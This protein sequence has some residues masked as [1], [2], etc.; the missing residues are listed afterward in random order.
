MPRMLHSQHSCALLGQGQDTTCTVARIAPSHG[1]QCC[2]AYIAYT[3]C[4]VA[5]PAL[6]R[7][8]H[9]LDSLHCCTACVA[10][11]ACTVARPALLRSKH[12]CTACT[13]AQP[14]QP[15]IPRARTR[16]RHAHHREVVLLCAVCRYFFAEMLTKLAGLGPQLYAA[17]K[18]NWF[19]ALVT[20]VG[21][22][23]FIISVLPSANALG[24][25]MSVFRAFRL[26]RILRLARSW[27]SLLLN[28]GLHVLHCPQLQPSSHPQ[29]FA[30]FASKCFMVDPPAAALLVHCW[31]AGHGFFWL[32]DRVLLPGGLHAQTTLFSAAACQGAPSIRML[33]PCCSLCLLTPNC[34]QVEGAQ[35]LCP[36]GFMYQ[37]CPPVLECYVPC[38]QAEA[39]TWYA[40]EGSP[41]GEQAYCEI[42]PRTP[43]LGV[44]PQYWA[45]VGLPSM[46]VMNYNNIYQAM[47]TVFVLLT[48][49]DY[50]VNM[51]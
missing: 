3:A 45:Q 50:D 31:I 24:G 1:L 47:L 48:G 22:V 14:A 23:E 25:A 12:C 40:V 26:L 32:Q 11:T 43:E 21:V 18:M 42:F 10:Y 51:K 46:I 19:D 37:E 29:G 20:I 17:D 44:V 13:V 35:Q 9:S 27:K 49:D 36:P 34:L 16:Q 38:T 15:C 28:H 7:N 4:T 5:R 41:Y 30:W 2:T 33:A 8:L 6:S 39:L